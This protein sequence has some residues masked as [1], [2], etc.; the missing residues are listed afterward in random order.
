MFSVTLKY[1][2]RRRRIPSW[3]VVQRVPPKGG[4]LSFFKAIMN[5]PWIDAKKILKAGIKEGRGARKFNNQTFC[6]F[7]SMAFISELLYRRG[8]RSKLCLYYGYLKVRWISEI[9]WSVLKVKGTF[10]KVLFGILYFVYFSALLNCFCDVFLET[11]FW[12][13]YQFDLP[14]FTIFFFLSW[15]KEKN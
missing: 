12:F 11:Y 2:N 13:K 3:T 14:K 8:I 7:K 5:I 6:L 10:Y 4:I 1:W 15:K 9:F